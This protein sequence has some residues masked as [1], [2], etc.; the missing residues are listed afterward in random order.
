MTDFNTPVEGI[1]TYAEG[2]N[3]RMVIAPKG[4]WEHAAYQTDK[5]FII[6]VK[7]VAENPNKL[8]QGAQ[9]RLYRAK[10]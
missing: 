8:T 2:D 1:D 7:P 5:K 4:M 9:G 10:S 3:V 6:E